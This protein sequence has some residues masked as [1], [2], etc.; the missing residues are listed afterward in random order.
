MKFSKD[1]KFI[2]AWGKMGSG[3]G[4]FNTPHSLAVDSKGHVFVADRGNNRIQIFD[5][6][7]KFIDRM[8]AVRPSERDLYFEGR[9]AIFGR[10]A[11]G[12]KD[13][14]RHKARYPYWQ[15]ERWHGEGFYSGSLD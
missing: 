1:G 12:R 5:Q 7:G 15:R 2:K 9:H 8:E 10:L 11:V 3:P 6:D 14:P 4:E 13:Q